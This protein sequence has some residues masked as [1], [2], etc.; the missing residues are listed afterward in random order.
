MLTYEAAGLGTITID[1]RILMSHLR[2]LDL[3]AHDV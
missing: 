2:Q 1:L 3:L